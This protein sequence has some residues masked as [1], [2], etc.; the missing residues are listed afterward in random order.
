MKNRFFSL[1]LFWLFCHFG[2]GE[3]YSSDVY[4]GLSSRQSVR[5]SA[6]IE[7]VEP[8]FWWCGMKNSSLQLMVYGPDIATYKPEIASPRVVLKEV[9]PMES[10][11]YQILYLDVKDAVPGKFRIDFVKGKSRLKYDYELKERQSRGEERIGFDASDVVYLLMPDRFANGD[12][13]NDCILMKCPYTVNRQD[14]NARHG[15]DLAGI[16]QHLD[17]LDSLGITAIWTTPVLENDMGEGSYH[18]Y[19]ATDYYKIDP[20]LGT[21]EDYVRLAEEMHRHGMK[22]IMDMVFNHCGSKHV[23]LFDPPTH[24]WFNNNT[25]KY[26]ETNHNKTVF[27]DPYASD[28]DRQELMDGWFVPTMPDLNQ[29]NRFVADYLIQ[30]SIWWIEYAGLDGVRQDTYVYPEPEMMI[31]WCKEVFEE[32]PN[33]NIVGEVMIPNNPFGTAYWQRKSVMN[34]NSDT[35]LKSVMDFHLR[36]IASKVFH[37]ETSWNSGLQLLF[38]HFA[39]DGCYPD[40]YNVMRLL[41]N[42]DTDRFFQKEPEN[43]NAYKQ[44]IVLLLTIPGIPQLYYGQ[45]LLMTGS[46][47]K[48]FGYVRPD[49]PGGWDGDAMNVFQE[50]GRTAM[51]QEAFDFMKRVLHWRKGNEIISKGKMKHFMPRNQ[52]YV[53]ERSY[54]GN[55]V[56]I[57]MNGV[58]KEV[59]FELAPYQEVIKERTN[60]KD[61]LTGKEFLLRDKLRLQPK[62]VLVLEL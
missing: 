62:E 34:G 14:A 51:Q 44:A 21:N 3:V 22:L 46:T 41:E 1:L 38:E 52:V 48:D 32:Y 35:R 5:K 39:Y 43:L 45:E 49:M 17:Y 4:S 10:P 31:R 27:F 59:E 26:V 50:S 30:N 13:S 36:E 33:F 19:A 42:H 61:V 54:N 55:S 18:G 29:R 16:M 37:E 11:N 2:V 6:K 9:C 24:D 25:G 28:I 53:Y 15:G 12:E 20:R 56:L 40:I 8:A 7:K 57:V 58:S 47:K 23:W 60:A